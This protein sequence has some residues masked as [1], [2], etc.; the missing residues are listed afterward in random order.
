MGNGTHTSIKP[1]PS[2]FDGLQDLIQTGDKKGLLRRELTALGYSS[3]Q[4][5]RALSRA[6]QLGLI[7][8]VGQGVYAV[9][10]A[11]IAEIMPEVL[12]KLGYQVQPT[13]KLKNYSIRRSGVTYRLDRP[14]RRFI[15]RNGIVATFETPNGKLTEVGVRKVM[16]SQELPTSHEIDE[17]FRTFQYCHS[18]AR[19]EKDMV[20]NRVLDV[21]D[22]HTDPEVTF[23]IEGGTSLAQ[24]QGVISRFSEDL[25]IRVVFEDSG[26][27]ARYDLMR[28]VGA[29]LTERIADELPFLQPTNKG[30]LRRDGVI[31]TIIFDY[32]GN[33]EH[34]DVVHGVKVELLATPVVQPLLHVI[35]N[36]RSC[37][38]VTPLEILAGKFAALGERLPGRGDGNPDLVRH[39]HDISVSAPIISPQAST[40]V[41]LIKDVS[42]VL[43]EVVTELSRPVWKNH[44]T[45]YMQKMGSLPT[46]DADRENIPRTNMAWTN[47]LTQFASICRTLDVIG[48]ED[49]ETVSTAVNAMLAKGRPNGLAL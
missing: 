21:Y 39:V 22:D 12:P 10:D 23:A 27:D 44:Y 25:D 28:D 15:M 41:P 40:M 4:V 35:R 31:H 2:A 1:V 17:H 6:R 32:D 36:H 30:R 46:F 48:D 49:L 37:P 34:Q 8:R 33:A 18:P 26:P 5:D 3:R 29:R 47:V 9:G 7:T 14:C 24:Y 38:V 19:A 20:V 45:R 16:D 42:G 11:R 13:S 43:P